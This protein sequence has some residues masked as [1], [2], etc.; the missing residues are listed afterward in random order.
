M[1]LDPLLLGVLACPEDKGPL[2]YFADEDRLYN[3]R[4]HRSYEVR[5][6]IPVMLIDEADRGVRRGAPA[7]DGQ[8]RC[9]R[10]NLHSGESR[11]VSGTAGGP[12]DGGGSS[13]L[14]VDTLDMW[15]ATAGLPEQVAEAVARS[16]GLAGLPDRDRVE[17]VVVLGMGG[18]GIAG[19]VLAATAAPFM[20]VPVSV[21][22]GYQPPDFVG[23]GTLV[24]A[25]SFSGDTEETLEAAG[26]AYEA[27][28]ALVVVS[29]GGELVRLAEEWRVPVVPVPTG[30]PQPRAALGAMSVPPI[31]V[32]EEIGLF[33]G[34]VH[35]I[36]QAVEQLKRRRDELVRPGNL[37]E[38]VARLIGRTIPLVHSSE[39]LGAAAALR[40]KA[41]VNENAK[42][43]GLLQ[44][45]SRAVPQR[46][47]RLGAARR[48]HP[49]DHH[50]GQPAP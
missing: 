47:R 27:G 46:G 31:V 20:A 11:R 43:P 33:P 49:P 22:K 21:V 6:G 12:A 35:W 7:A 36:A 41:Q 39:A 5:D 48:R 40:W 10:G 42:C 17:N 30:I 1:S 23:A 16:R 18:S 2:L 34:A 13:P 4:L 24:F 14:P 37:A 44:R 32:L 15:G 19:D 26:L 9:R 50:A 38:D 29:G 28:A 3:P 25:L 8:S 45:L